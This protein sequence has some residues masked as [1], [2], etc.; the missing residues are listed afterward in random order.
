M[1]HYIPID[2]LWIDIQR[3]RLWPEYCDEKHHGSCHRLSEWETI[4][5]APSIIL[6]DV[7]RQHLVQTSQPKKYVA[8]SYVWGKLP[9]VLET[10][11]DN[12][13][14]LQHPGALDSQPWASR[15]PATVR[16]AM[17]FTRLMGK[18]Y[19]WADRLCI[20]QDD[21]RHKAEQLSWMSS[22]YANSYFTIVA[23]DGND[24]NYGLRGACMSSSSSRSY[25]PSILHFSPTCSMMQAPEFENQFNMKE[26]HK[27]GWT[28]QERTLSNRNLVFFQGKVFW[29][30]RKSIWTEELADAPD[31]GSMSKSSQRKSDRYSFEFFRWPDLHQYSKLVG[32]YNNRLLTYQSDALQAFSAIINAL[33]RSF[34][35][36]FFYGVPEL[37][38]DFGLLWR[39]NTPC[40]R[41]TDADESTVYP[42]FPSW[43]WVG[44][45]GNVVLS[46]LKKSHQL[47]L[48]TESSSPSIEIHPM[49]IWYKTNKLTGGK[50]RIDNSY[51][52]FQRM[53]NDSLVPLPA[54]WSRVKPSNSTLNASECPNDLRV[55]KHEGVSHT[56]FIHPIPIATK[57]LNP[58]PDTWDSHLTF[59]TTRCFLLSGPVLGT[60]HHRAASSNI[61]NDFVPYCLSFVLMDALRQWAGMVYSDFSDPNEIAIGQRCE[62]III[63]AG[64]AH[65]DEN[66]SVKAWLEE[67]KYIDDIKE[68]D[69]YEFYNVLWIE[70]KGDIA[71]RRALG[72]VW[73]DA[74]QRQDVEEID[75][76]LG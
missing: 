72:R 63:S 75:V 25:H 10:T 43:S 44:W 26:W 12:F 20:I 54:G 69:K 1:E 28:Y 71:Y 58:N 34:Q 60:A 67:W 30:C 56:E 61:S 3:I 9:V 47:L 4:D 23:A 6:I 51:Y 74:W 36:G 2:P 45:E 49:I 57:P 35:G 14:Q 64:V 38:F 21:G 19:L 39:P 13:L 31:G 48:D 50:C 73:K 65:I 41:R 16:D 17:Y 55:F 33:S 52:S 66:E 62:V 40:Q 53:R 15:L 11:K 8:L 24:A 29:E 70:R 68:K 7:D 46:C 5:P 42:A 76:I 27:R 18:S 37:Y 59:K 22:I 32:S